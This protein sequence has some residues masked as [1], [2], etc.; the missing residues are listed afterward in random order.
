[1]NVSN[2]LRNIE[3]LVKCALVVCGKFTLLLL[4]SIV[5]NFFICRKIATLVD[6]NAQINRTLT[7]ITLQAPSQIPQQPHPKPQPGLVPRRN[8]FD[9]QQVIPCA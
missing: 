5:A 3:V 1:M 2:H 8:A 7:P 6:E 4:G 9:L